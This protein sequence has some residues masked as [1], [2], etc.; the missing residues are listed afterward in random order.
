MI[1][2][3]LAC[4]VVLLT[5][6]GLS[7]K[8]WSQQERINLKFEQAT[9]VQLFDLIQQKTNLKFVFNHED[10]QGFK[11][12]KQNFTGKTV[13][14][15]LDVVFK[16]KPFAY[17]ILA[18]HIVI[19]RV[20]QEKKHTV[21]GNVVDES[22]LPLPGVS[23]IIKGTTV[24]VAT[25][26]DGNFQLDIAKL[27]G[28]ILQFSMVGM[29]TQEVKIVPNRL[30]Y[31]VVM[32]VDAQE[33]EDVVCTGYQTLNKINTTGSFSSIRPET[34]ELRGSIGLDRLLE[35]AVPGL[36]VYNNDIRI[37]GGSSINA[38]TKPLYIVDGFE[39]DELPDN[40]NLVERISI[41][42]DA[43]AAAIWGARAANGVIVIE[44]KKGKKGEMRVSYS[45]NFKVE[46]KY[47][48]DDLRHG[49]IVR[50]L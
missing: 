38:G 50:L 23:V 16:G 7:A 39:V 14:E 45:G 43:A 6:S 33:L 41:L 40:M 24:G 18:D 26:A 31:K 34:I 15:I 25:D 22:G 49:L 46:S 44:T 42:K 37:R 8:V 35:G 12:D 11:A 9:F 19:S 5:C 48:F 17:E 21:K 13:S 20:A 10:V 4:L 29:K 36:T 30:S 1:K 27:E 47:D 3:K 32:Q 2:V 28:V